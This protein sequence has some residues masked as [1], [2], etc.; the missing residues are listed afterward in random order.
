MSQ[1]DRHLMS[2]PSEVA[3]LPPGTS[4]GG[5]A[6]EAPFDGALR[7]LRRHVVLI[8]IAIVFTGGAAYAYSARKEKEY[9]ASASILFRDPSTDITGTGG[10]DFADPQRVAATNQELLSLAV[11]AEA[12]SKR[13]HGSI[14][15]QAI[16]S[17][18]TVTSTRESDI[19]AVEATSGDPNRAAQVANAYGSAFIAFRRDSA[20]RQIGEALTLA[21]AALQALPPTQRTGTEGENLQARIDQLETAMAL[22]TGGAE[23]VQPASVPSSPS[24][25]K[26][27]RAGILGAFLGAILGFSIAA[28]RER[29]N[30]AVSETDELEALIGAP[31]LARVPRS[32]HLARRGAKALSGEEAEA[33]RMLRANL[34]FIVVE[35]RLASLLIVSAAPGEGKSTVAR[36]LAETIAAMGDSVVLVEADMHRHDGNDASGRRRGLSTVLAGDDL[37]ESLKAVVVEPAGGGSRL[38]ITWLPSGPVPPNASELLESDRMQAVLVDLQSRFDLVIIDSPPLGV[39]SDALP[40]VNQVSGVIAV[41]ALGKTTDWAVAELARA[42]RRH[43]GNLLGVVANFARSRKRAA[44]DYY[45]TR[46]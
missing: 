43:D 11:V 3:A 46:S 7:I 6:A 21:R 17:A 15:A 4:V 30:V 41:S 20:R 9:T 2:S 16:A 37:E 38:A 29:R 28:F 18:V 1:F 42:V 27:V 33:F 35:S 39:M 32:R 31:L 14:G 5:R 22:Q 44:G 24:A 8:A 45:N 23:L 26:P 12:A 40:L 19:A 25:P 36:G 13:L 10:S 34:R